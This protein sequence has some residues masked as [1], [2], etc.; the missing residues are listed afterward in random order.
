MDK[1]AL[2][3]SPGCRALRLF[4]IFR[5]SCRL[6][7]LVANSLPCPQIGFSSFS[8]SSSLPGLLALHSQIN[9]LHRSLGLSLYCERSSEDMVPTKETLGSLRESNECTESFEMN[10]LCF[11]NT[12]K[13][14]S[15]QFKNSYDDLS[16][17]S[18]LNQCQMKV[19]ERKERVNVFW[20]RV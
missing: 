6:P 12:Y 9:D 5:K 10:Q 15:F 20:L 17:N 19:I 14:R 7:A 1:Y 4:K 13:I 18:I 8:V 2:L 16:G 11:S 3:S